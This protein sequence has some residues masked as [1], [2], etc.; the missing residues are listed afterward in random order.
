MDIN[1]LNTIL[2]SHGTVGFCG[3]NGSDANIL[4]IAIEL[5]NKT[6][7]GIDSFNST[8]ATEVIPE[9]PNVNHFGYNDGMLKCEYQ[10]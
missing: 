8:I 5:T 7:T 2:T 3:Y 4:I 6:Q 1:N 10:K 9:F